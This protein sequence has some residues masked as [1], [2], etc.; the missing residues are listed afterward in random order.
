MAILSSEAKQML[1]SIH[2]GLVATADLTGKPNVSPKGSFQ[3]LDDEHVLFADIHSPQTIANLQANPQVSAIVFDPATRHG[4]RVWGQAQ[5]LNAGD[6]FDKVNG[7][8]AARN[9]QAK[10]VVVVAVDNFVTF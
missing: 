2:P 10:H 7:A 9:M 6:L 1:A 4:C 5:I 3:V 8:L